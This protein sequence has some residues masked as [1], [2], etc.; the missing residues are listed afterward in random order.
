[1]SEQSI[2]ERAG[3]YQSMMQPIPGDHPCGKNLEYDPAFIMLQTKLQPK[4]AAEYGNFIEVAE[5]NNWTD[6][7]RKCLELLNNSRDIRLFIILMRCRM[8]QVGVGALQEGLEAIL[9]CLD[10]W[11]D[12]LH[13]QLFDEGEFEPLMRGNAFA[14]L[15]D[16]DGFIADFRNQQLPKAAGVQ[17][18]IKEFEKAH[19]VPREEGA[20]DEGT[21]EAVKQEWQNRSDH[22]ILSLQNAYALLQGLTTRLNNSLGEDTPDF[23]RMTSVLRH[24]D[25]AIT[26]I[27]PIVVPVALEIPEVIVPSPVATEMQTITETPVITEVQAVAET[28]T[29]MPIEVPQQLQAVIAPSP[30]LQSVQMQPQPVPIQQQGIQ[31]RA[32][33]LSRLIEVREWFTA[34][35]P[36]SPVIALLAFS[37]KTIGKSFGELLQFIPQELISKLNEGQE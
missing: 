1:M 8:R 32:D 36:S 37:E 25:A 34:S 19:S 5:P 15:E 27:A 28:Q 23:V 13:P 24:F 14:E 12:Q 3:Y 11:P 16:I 4:Q 17:L 18:S 31:N 30:Q 9:W 22:T 7:E 2:A 20:L 35:E 33:A 10:T 29:V 26:P 6:I 21:L